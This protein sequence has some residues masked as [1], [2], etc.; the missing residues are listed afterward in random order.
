[1]STKSF[2]EVWASQIALRRSSL[3]QE[4]VK[5]TSLHTQLVGV[6]TDLENSYLKLV[7]GHLWEG[8]GHPGLDQHNSSFNVTKKHNAKTP[9]DGLPWDE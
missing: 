3:L 5:N 2:N 7:G 9:R 8:V 6:L 4:V 1:L